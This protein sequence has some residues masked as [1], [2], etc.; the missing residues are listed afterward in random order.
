MAFV[1]ILIISV[2][3]VVVTVPEGKS[4]FGAEFLSLLIPNIGLPL[5][6]T[7]ALAFATKCMTKENLLV[8]VL[9]SCETMA[10][11]SVICT[12]KTS[13]L[14]QNVMTIVAGPLASTP[15]LSA[16]SIRISLTPTQRTIAD[17]TKVA[18]P[19]SPGMT[20]PST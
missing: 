15:S 9:G 8:R 10:N 18:T 4:K 1:Q 16:V 2:T 17:H 3:L 19:A 7:L 11:A 5:A 6:V 13:T 12:D 14:T 20:F